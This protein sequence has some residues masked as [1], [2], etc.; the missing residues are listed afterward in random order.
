MFAGAGDRYR[1]FVLLAASLIFYGFLLE[2]H[3]LIALL[4]VAVVSYAGGIMVGKAADAGR[5]HALF[6]GAIGCNLLVLVGLKYLPFLTG[7]FTSLLNLVGYE[8]LLPAAPVL[9]SI[10]V[11][12][13]VFQALSYLIDVYLEIEEPERHLGYFTLSLAFFPK[14]LQ[15]PIERAGD[16]LP[17]LRVPYR[18]DYDNMRSGLLLFGWGLFKKI[19]VA[20]RLGLFVDAVYG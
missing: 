5:R 12:F 19:V 1:W 20:D 9:V 2:P 14:L 6:L 7:N 11:S 13:F 10:G 4:G 3:L 8:S 16:L 15:G 17:Q 18:F